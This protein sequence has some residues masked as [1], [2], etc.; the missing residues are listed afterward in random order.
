[1]PETL[2]RCD[3]CGC[4]NPTGAEV[5]ARCGEPFEIQPPTPFVE[6]PGE[7][8][9]ATAGSQTVSP[10]AEVLPSPQVE[11]ASPSTSAGQ[12]PVPPTQ[13]TPASEW[14]AF[15]P[16][17]R[18]EVI[19]VDQVQ[20]VPAGFNLPACLTRL[21]WLVALVGTPFVL[22]REAIIRL[23][24]GSIILCVV[25]LFLLIRLVSP[26]NLWAVLNI[27]R[28]LSPARPREERRVPLFFFHLRD[29]QRQ[30]HIVR[31]QGQLTRGN[32]RPGDLLA[33]WGRWR[34]GT[35]VFRRAINGRTR[36]WV[37][38][39]PNYSWLSLAITVAVLAFVLVTFWEP[40]SG[41][42]GAIRNHAQDGRLP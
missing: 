25:G 7:V 22:V 28:M 16:Q 37:F 32:V 4:A 40:V 23:G 31:V 27:F 21:L 15:P 12:P 3:A 33:V 1:M 10:H 36:S 20:Q 18:G 11:E 6:A 38:L 19:D 13:K 35:L 26:L 9:V 8:L 39:R 17:L 24:F 34:D 41:L 42:L 2:E 14:G 5:C 30:E 29:G